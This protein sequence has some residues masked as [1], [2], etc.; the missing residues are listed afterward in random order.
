[1]K[2]ATIIVRVLLG[3]LFIFASVAYFL[4]LIE[5]P[6]MEGN[7]LSFNEGLAASGY[8]FPLIKTIELLGGLAL[9]AGL[10]VPLATV[11]LFPISLNILLMHLLLDPAGL[12]V[13]IFVIGANLFLAYACRHHYRALFSVKTNNPEK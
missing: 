6:E 1:M 11:V 3:L 12:P 10:F 7:I 8:L 5:P 4:N 13:A 9:L 2:I